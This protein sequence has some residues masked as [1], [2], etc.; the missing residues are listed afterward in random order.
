MSS[1]AGKAITSHERAGGTDASNP[2]RKSASLTK[3]RGLQPWRA[4]D[5]ANV[6]AILRP[7]RR[8]HLRGVL[9]GT[10][11]LLPFRSHACLSP[12][13]RL[14]T[15]LRRLTGG[16]WAP[17]SPLWA[18]VAIVTLAP[19]GRRAAMA[20]GSLPVLGLAAVATTQDTSHSPHSRL[21]PSPRLS[22]PS[23][24]TR[25][26]PAAPRCNGSLLGVPAGR[27]A[28]PGAFQR[29]EP[30]GLLLLDWEQRC[31]LCRNARRAALSRVP[32]HPGLR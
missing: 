32:T 8:P 3:K 31:G 10:T 28:T 16:P 25:R 13:S 29:S 20:L 27:R 12:S 17:W 2:K 30:K 22:S 19:M 23:R 9:S 1:V 18:L 15:A 5:P 26:D 14:P 11:F 21:A 24:R 7:A 6:I 4:R